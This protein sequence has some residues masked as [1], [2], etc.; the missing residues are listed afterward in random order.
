MV[1]FP[2]LCVRKFLWRRNSDLFTFLVASRDQ[3]I[4]PSG[5]E[6]GGAGVAGSGRGVAVAVSTGTTTVAV[7][8]AAGIS[9]A[10]VTVVLTATVAAGVASGCVP[11]GEATA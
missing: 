7:G 11:G 1:A 8:A 3:Y 2:R 6:S 9:T 5:V 10:A 4:H